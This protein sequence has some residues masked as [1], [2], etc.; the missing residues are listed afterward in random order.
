VHGGLFFSPDGN[1]L[2]YF[3]S[4][5][6]VN[7]I[8]RIHLISYNIS[9]I[10]KEISGSGFY[11][12]T[13]LENGTIIYSMPGSGLS[14]IPEV[15]GEPK[16]ITFPDKSKGERAHYWP[17]VLPDGKHLLFSIAPKRASDT[18]DS[19]IGLLSLE[20]M[21]WDTLIYERSLRPQYIPSQDLQKGYIIYLSHP[22]HKAVPFD[23][24]RLKITGKS[25][26]LSEEI[27]NGRPNESY[28][29]T[30][31]FGTL[32]YF[33]PNKKKKPPLHQ[34]VWIDRNGNETFIKNSWIVRPRISPDGQYIAY[35]RV[36]KNEY[37]IDSVDPIIYIYNIKTK[38]HRPLEDGNAPIWNPDGEWIT[39]SSFRNDKH[40]IY[41]RRSNGIGLAELLCESENYILP[42]SW[43]P[44]GKFLAFQETSSDYTIRDIWIYDIHV[45]KAK[46]FCSTEHREYAAVFSDDGKWIFYIS[47]ENGADEIWVKKYPEGDKQIITTEFAGTT[48]PVIGMNELF[49]RVVG[50]KRYNSIKIDD[51]KN[52]QNLKPPV[53]LFNLNHAFTWINTPAGFDYDRN[54]DRF[55]M[56]KQIKDFSSEI[57]NHFHIVVNWHEE[58]NTI[59]SE[60]K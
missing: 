9:N 15:G 35:N 51:L 11:G 18:R 23:L 40:G 47:D 53:K 10:T 42:C 34:L 37:N 32:A 27:Y 19:R 5:G 54:N 2:G 33:S 56:V 50:R 26:I 14:Q 20:T 30:S 13:W 52:F 60:N 7:H 29:A 49:Y 25:K 6:S 55:L 57:E 17:H 41:R 16:L 38:F 48:E 8:K 44:D 3:E 31:R 43:S 45:G 12:A 24:K 36:I 21:K 1:S 59:L 22:Y 39:F 28:F 4:K 58:L 46:V